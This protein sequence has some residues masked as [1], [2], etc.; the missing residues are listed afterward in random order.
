M[1]MFVCP[2]CFKAKTVD[3]SKQTD[4]GGFLEVNCQCTCGHSYTV[5]LNKRNRDRVAITLPGAFIRYKEG[6]TGR[7][8]QKVAQA[9]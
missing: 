5:M 9:P 6:I 4:K 8:E 7:R 1:A 2:E 3:V